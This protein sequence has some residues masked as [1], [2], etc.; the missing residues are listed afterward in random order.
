MNRFLL[1]LSWLVLLIP[2]QAVASVKDELVLKAMFITRFVQFTEWPPPPIL[3]HRFC[4]Y[5]D[6]AMHQALT[7]QL[8]AQHAAPSVMLIE[9]PTQVA[10]CHVLV[11]TTTNREALQGWADAVASSPL[12]II[13]DNSEAFRSL[14]TISLVTEPDGMTFRINHSSALARGLR[15]SAQLLKLAREV[16]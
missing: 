3:Q 15:L 5:Q 9:S 13:A 16:K 4:V 14:A 6:Q 11:L 2:S 10:S 8:G 12:L 7:V 1:L